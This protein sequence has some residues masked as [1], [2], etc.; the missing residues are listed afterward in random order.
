MGPYGREL[1]V[2]YPTLGPVYTG[3]VESNDGIKILLDDPDADSAVSCSRYNMWSPLRA[4]ILDSHGYLQPYLPFD[5]HP[6]SLE[7]SCDRDSQGDVWFADIG[8]S[9]VRSINIDNLDSGL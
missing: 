2:L 9:I 6:N 8:V 3:L 7:L 1:F 4:R 5:Q